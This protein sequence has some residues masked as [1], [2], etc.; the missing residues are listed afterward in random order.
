M[1]TS[2]ALGTELT[3]EDQRHVL[4]SFVHRFTREHKP[5]WASKP[6]KDGKPYPV[7]FASDREWL[8]NT[9]FAV[10]RNG[11][12]DNRVTECQSSQTWPDNPELRI[13]ATTP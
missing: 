2:Y 7:Q 9:R 11:R 1:E 13:A 3:Q 8:A 6:W 5:T 4:N 10:R 12:L